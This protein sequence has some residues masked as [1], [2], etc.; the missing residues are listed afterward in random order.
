MMVKLKSKEKEI[1]EKLV[2]KRVTEIIRYRNL[3]NALLGCYQY[4]Q[5]KKEYTSFLG[6]KLNIFSPDIVIKSKDEHK[7][8]IVGDGKQGLPNPPKKEDEMTWEEYMK[9]D[10]VVKYM[11]KILPDLTKTID[12]YSQKFD[13]ITEPHD[14]FI[15]SPIEKTTAIKILERTGKLNTKAIILNFSFSSTENREYILRIIKNKGNFSDEDVNND[16]DIAGGI[17]E[18]MHE[19]T[20]LM[21][22]HKLYLAEK[23]DYNAPIEWIM[24]VIWQY[25]IPDIANTKDKDLIIKKLSTGH[26]LIEV[27]LKQV[28][29]FIK[30]NYKL[31][32][33]N[34]DKELISFTVIRKAM[35]HFTDITEV[36]IID[37][38]TSNPK[39]RIIWKKLPTDNLI[40]E[41][42][43]KV[44]KAEFDKIIK[45]ELEKPVLPE[46]TPEQKELKDFQI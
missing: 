44:N 43:K 25:I 19:F 2:E 8:D 24:L 36:E 38:S 28:S 41:F 20:E 42:V 15:L 46:K 9:L 21:S 3:T 33:F 7:S 22:K 6:A 27:S 23:E 16:F 13:K 34:G 26:L 30:N 18:K 17:T 32:T 14:F 4:F 40:F 29:D 37:E 35:G 1:T 10:V 11:D 45:E 5:K 12:K 39:Y 31:P